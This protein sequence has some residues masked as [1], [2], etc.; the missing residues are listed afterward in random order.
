MQIKIFSCGGTI[1]KVYFDAN[2]DFSVGEPQI[3]SIF[4][5]SNVAFDFRIESLM[6]KDSLEMTVEDRQL[7]RDRIAGDEARQIL[8]THGTDTMAVTAEF[9]VGIPGKVIVL[10][11]SMTPARFRVSDAVFNIGCAVGALQ[12]KPAGVFIAMNGGVF[13]AGNVRK[14]RDLQRFE[15][16]VSAE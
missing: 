12:S 6:R 7:L 13:I 8:V 2:S 10:T 4:L 16:I 11:G 9:L 5:D 14:N 15:E 3:K 1:D